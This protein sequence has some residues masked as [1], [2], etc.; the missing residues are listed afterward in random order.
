MDHLLKQYRWFGLVCLQTA[1]TLQFFMLRH[2]DAW[3]EKYLASDSFAAKL[4]VFLASSSALF[5]LTA[6]L[7][8]LWYEHFGWK[9]LNPRV[10]IE[11]IWKYNVVYYTPD[12]SLLRREGQEKILNILT[13]I[14]D[15]HGQ[16]WVDQGVF[17]VSVQE[18]VGYLGE[19]PTAYKVTWKGTA[20]NISSQGTV[21]LYYTTNHGGVK[22][23][24]F[25]DLV[26]RRRDKRGSPLELFGH[27]WMISEGTAF[28]LRGEI[29][30]TR[31]GGAE[32]R[33]APSNRINGTAGARIATAEQS[34]ALEPAAGPVSIGKSSP[35]AQ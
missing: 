25:D 18:G 30:Y 12:T 10:N 16:M 34:H 26:V 15:N 31:E 24:G 29:T 2:V 7:P 14:K 20:V 1:I 3:A 8:L 11:G 28:V 6:K 33:P 17:C 27:F 19:G 35:P 4:L 32:N 13:H 22:F 23:N 5:L 9:L 21:G